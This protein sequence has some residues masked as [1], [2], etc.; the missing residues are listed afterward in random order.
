MRMGARITRLDHVQ[1]AMPAGEESAARAFYAG[2]LGLSEIPKPPGLAKRGG[3][4]FEG[5]GFQVH[6]GVE[7]DFHPAKK[8]HPCFRV[9][10]LDRLRQALE[11]AGVETIPDSEIPGVRRFYASDPFGNRVEFMQEG[12]DQKGDG[13]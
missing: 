9:D 7:A 1:I 2:I 4:W 10:D 12:A 11:D 3:A 6:L 5:S 13:T 8:A